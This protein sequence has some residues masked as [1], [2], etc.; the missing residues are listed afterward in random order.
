VNLRPAT[1][2]QNQ[3]NLG[4]SVRNSSGRKGVVWNKN[5]GRWQAQIGVRGKLVYLGLYDDIEVASNAYAKAASQFF[6]KFAR[7][8]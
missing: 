1:R 5:V 4:L 6:D 8:I 2:S 7:L 3:A